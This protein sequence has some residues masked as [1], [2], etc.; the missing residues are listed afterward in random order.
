MI[1]H[2][3][4]NEN[5]APISYEQRMQNMIDKLSSYDESH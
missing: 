5:Q 3:V 4:I 1:E 2:V